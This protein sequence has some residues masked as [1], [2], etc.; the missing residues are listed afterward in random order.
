MRDHRTVCH[1]PYD[2]SAGVDGW[3]LSRLSAPDKVRMIFT[4]PCPAGCT[5]VSSSP[6]ETKN[7]FRYFPGEDSVDILRCRQANAVREKITAGER[8]EPLPG[9]RSG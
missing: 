4:G 7:Q 5:V 3:S 1:S 6:V 2:L 9:F 8:L